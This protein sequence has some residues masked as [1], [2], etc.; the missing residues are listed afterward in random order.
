MHTFRHLLNGK[1]SKGSGHGAVEDLLSICPLPGPFL[2]TFGLKNCLLVPLGA[3]K[4]TF[5][6]KQDKTTYWSNELFPLKDFD[7]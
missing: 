7:Q 5:C 2:A 6:L 3:Y 4:C 1:I